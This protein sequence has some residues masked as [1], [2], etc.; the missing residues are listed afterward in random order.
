MDDYH[1]FRHAHEIQVKE[2]GYTN[3]PIMLLSLKN[4]AC[5]WCNGNFSISMASGSGSA[6]GS[7]PIGSGGTPMGGGV[8]ASISMQGPLLSQP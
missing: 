8:K 1:E 5:K 2:C 7:G 4:Y 3:F 6:N